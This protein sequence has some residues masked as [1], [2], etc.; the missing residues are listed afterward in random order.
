MIKVCPKCFKR[1]EPQKGRYPKYCSEQCKKE[2][3]A[4]KRKSNVKVLTCK[5][6]GKEFETNKIYAPKYCKECRPVN[7]KVICENCGKEFAAYKS[8]NRKFCSEQCRVERVSNNLPLL[9]V[10]CKTCGKE[11]QTK[12]ANKKYCN[13][14]CRAADKRVWIDCKTCG[15]RFETYKLFGRKFCSNECRATRR[16]SKNA[17]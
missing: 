17:Q 9:T 15:K 16:I 10:N 6:C 7:H 11:F 1:F 3:K 2:Y 14:Y 5:R 13:K 12:D 8:K 4:T